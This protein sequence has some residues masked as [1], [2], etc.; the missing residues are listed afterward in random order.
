[1]IVVSS[2]LFVLAAIAVSTSLVSPSVLGLAT[3]PN[4]I[5]E[6]SK[7]TSPALEPAA[8]TTPLNEITSFDAALIQRHVV[9]IPPA[10]IANQLTAAN[11][12]GVQPVSSLDA[13]LVAKY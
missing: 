5:S 6:S 3:E 10:Q 1:I 13:A 11:V 7:E 12:T 8:M 9:E 2:I 4:E